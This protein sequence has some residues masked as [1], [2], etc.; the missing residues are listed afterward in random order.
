LFTHWSSMYDGIARC[1]TILTRIDQVEFSSEDIKGRYLAETKF[2]RGLLYFHLVRKFGAIPLSTTGPTSKEEV[3]ALAVRVSEEE[4]YAQIVTDLT[5]AL[6]SDLPT[7]QQEYAVGRAS[8]VAV[9]SLLGHVY[10]TMASTLTE[11]TSAHLQQAE[12]Y[13][14]AAYQARSFGR[15]AEI[16]YADVF[17]VDQKMSCPGLICQIQYLP[18]EQNYHSKIG[19]TS[20]AHDESINP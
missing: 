13:L 7:H 20:H 19:R 12:Q 1:N 10:L 2:V 15:L 11:G 16:P 9:Q 14:E 6:D 17:D 5:E 4:V 18:G 8:K 3:D